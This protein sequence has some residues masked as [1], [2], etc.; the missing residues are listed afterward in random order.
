MTNIRLF[1]SENRTTNRRFGH[2]S[3]NANGN[4]VL[5]AFV[6]DDSRTFVNDNGVAKNDWNIMAAPVFKYIFSSFHETFAVKS[7]DRRSVRGGF[8]R[9]VVDGGNRNVHVHI[10][11]TAVELVYDVNAT[12][13]LTMD[14]NAK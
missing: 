9:V 1:P 12:T 5:D 7:R 6:Y 2:F 14:A 8:S 10:T 11:W 13:V 3:F 4:S